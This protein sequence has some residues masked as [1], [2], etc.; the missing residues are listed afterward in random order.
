MRRLWLAWVLLSVSCASVPPRNPDQAALDQA[1]AHVLDGCYDCLIDARTI[2]TRVAAGKWR[3]QVLPRLF[4][5]EVLLTLRQKELALDFTE[6]LTRA[7]A[8]IKELPP[9]LEPGRYVAIVEAVPSDDVGTPRAE[10]RAF[11]S[12]PERRPFLARIP[13]E[14]QWLA[15]AP[16]FSQPFRQYVS[17]SLDCMYLSRPRVQ[18]QLPPAAIDRD[19]GPSAPAL[20]TYRFGICGQVSRAPME[21]VRAAV[22][23]FTEAAYFLARRELAEQKQIKV[24]ELLVEVY[25][26]FTQSPSVNY[27]SGNF[28]QLLGDCK[29]GLDFYDATIAFKPLH[30]NGLLGRTICLTYLKRHDEAIQAAT[31]ITDLRLDN[32]AEGYYW[33]ARNYYLLQQLPAARRDIESAKQ[34]ASTPQIHTMAGIIEHDQDDLDIAEKDLNIA[35]SMSGGDQNCTARWYLGLVEMKRTR[36]PQSGA[37]FV[38]AMGCYELSVKDNEQRR[39]A[40][41]KN[42]DLDPD[43]KTRQIAGFEAAIKEDRQQQY[44][45]AFNAANH[46]ARGGDTARAKTLVEIAAKDPSLAERVAELKRILGGG[47]DRR[48]PGIF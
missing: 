48:R 9:G 32:V 7:R 12:A 30:E 39:D 13:A 19:P 25:K 1:D 17:L 27:F 3:P 41:A 45:A 24:R 22:P 34:L 47:G 14:L 11:R 10:D 37:H 31:R 21:K 20:L 28:N 46:Y 23:R 40:I 26:R 44:S 2:Y 4:E 43:F 16:G 36:W 42:P 8:L 38:D 6:S 18:G 33:R 5:V 15:F 29:A 35:K